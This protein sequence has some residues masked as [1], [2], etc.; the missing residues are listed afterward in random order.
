MTV[1]SDYLQE[2]E[3]RKKNGLQPKPIDDAGLTRAIIQQI[4]DLQSPH[5]EDS[6]QFL[7]YNTLPGTTSAAGVKAMFLKEII[8]GKTSVA[9]ITPEFAFEQ[10]SHMKGGPS[11]EVLL[12]L[13]LGDD[14]E[15]SASAATVLKSQVF[16]Y[17]ADT[18]R[19]AA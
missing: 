12:D 14:A 11:I 18:E 8:L 7:I 10:L 4:K 5:R 17:D 13:A 2:I 19:L 1:Y 3:E 15:I 9:E 16:L 6:L